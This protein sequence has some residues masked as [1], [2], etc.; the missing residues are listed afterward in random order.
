VSAEY[1]ED[2]P[3]PRRLQLIVEFEG[4]TFSGTL[5]LDDEALLP[6]LQRQFAR[7]IGRP[8]GDVGGALDLDVLLDLL[9]LSIR[10]RLREGRLP[11][12]VAAAAPLTAGQPLSNAIRLS[13]AQGQRCAA[14]DEP[15][16]TRQHRPFYLSAHG[17]VVLDELCERIWLEE[18]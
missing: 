9:R 10:G 12:T 8:L 11:Q 13:P 1:L 17:T 18:R 14:C 4:H 15:I 7:F 6:F 2:Q 3:P 5:R 16:L